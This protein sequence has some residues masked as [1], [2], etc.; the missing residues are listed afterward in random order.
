MKK[1]QNLKQETRQNTSTEGAV[2]VSSGRLF[3][4]EVVQKRKKKKKEKT[5]TKNKKH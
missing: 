2:A 5:T 1:R 4:S 3:Q